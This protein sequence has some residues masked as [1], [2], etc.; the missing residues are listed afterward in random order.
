[1]L[2]AEG[3]LLWL[4]LLLL[5][6]LVVLPLGRRLGAAAEEVNLGGPPRAEAEGTPLALALPAGAS[7]ELGTVA[8]A[9]ARAG[10][11]CGRDLAGPVP[12]RL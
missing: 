4:W 5:L 7:L 11:R 9:L 8:R 10:T 12:W 1:V 2:L 3:A 6:G